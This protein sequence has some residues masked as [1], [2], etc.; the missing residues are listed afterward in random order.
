MIMGFG[1]REARLTR[2]APAPPGR[3]GRVWWHGE[4]GRR[5]R[6]PSYGRV[7]REP[8]PVQLQLVMFRVVDSQWLEDATLGSVLTN[9][10]CQDTVVMPG[11]VTLNELLFVV[12]VAEE[13]VPV[14][15]F[16]YN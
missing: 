12:S 9:L 16:V 4:G 1:R 14:S 10:T 13:L 8:G 15:V 3:P 2:P 6:P 11:L 5:C 7:R